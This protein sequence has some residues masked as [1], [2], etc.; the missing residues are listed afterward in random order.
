MHRVLTP[1]EVRGDGAKIF[2]EC[3]SSFLI[4]H[5]HGTYTSYSADRLP[6]SSGGRSYLLDSPAVLTCTNTSSRPSASS[7]RTRYVFRASH[8]QSTVGRMTNGADVLRTS[9]RSVQRDLNTNR[10]G[11]LTLRGTFP[12]ITCDI[13]DTFRRA[14]TG[15]TIL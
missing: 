14:M 12:G 4:I 3:P 15:Q 1:S 7:Q 9:G 10:T 5:C 8:D 2:L 11:K 13:Q 6:I